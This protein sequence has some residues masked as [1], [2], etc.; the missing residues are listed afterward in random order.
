MIED[1][2]I[3]NAIFKMIGDVE[4]LLGLGM[5]KLKSDIHPCDEM[6]YRLEFMAS[7]CFGEDWVMSFFIEYTKA[8]GAIE[9]FKKSD[10]LLWDRERSN[11]ASSFSRECVPVIL[12]LFIVREYT[13]DFSLSN[14]E[15]ADNLMEIKNA[16]GKIKSGT[17]IPTIYVSLA[18]NVMSLQN[19][20]KIYQEVVKLLPSKTSQWEEIY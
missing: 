9:L 4:H 8:I 3:D 5:P 7:H 1:S 15:M 13:L 10:H 19:S 12:S 14:F 18:N 17:S 16:V 11:V 20:G 2:P 6:F